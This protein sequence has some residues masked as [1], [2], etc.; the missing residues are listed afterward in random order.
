MMCNGVDPDLCLSCEIEDYQLNT[1]SLMIDAIETI[2]ERMD[3]T[4]FYNRKQITAFR[5]QLIAMGWFVEI[6][7]PDAVQVLHNGQCR[8]MNRY[9]YAF[10]IGQRYYV[11][12][13]RVA[14]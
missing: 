3:E 8:M 14:E 5:K 9:E 7:K 4:E 2:V 1:E 13:V 6:E 12:A 11:E 10:R